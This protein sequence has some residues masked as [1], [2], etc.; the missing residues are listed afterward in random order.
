MDKQIMRTFYFLLGNTLVS[1]IVN[2]T[3]WFAITFYTYLQ[4]QS[5]LATSIISGIYLITVS[6]TGFW[7]GSIVDANKKKNVMIAS[8]LASLTFYL[9]CFA[10]YQSVDQN[11]FKDIGNPTLWVF[12][13]LTMAGVLSGNLRSIA[14]PTLVTIMIPEERRDKANGLVGTVSGVAFMIVSIFSGFL[15]AHSGMYL[16]LLLGIIL[17]VL[18]IAHLL[19]IQIPEKEIVH[20][21]ETK[22]KGRI[23]IRGTI[24][25]IKSVPGLLS[26]I[27][28]A[29]FNNFLG[30]VFMALLDA[31]G[32][33]L[34]K[35]EVWGLI[36]GFLS[37]AFIFGGM[38]VATRGLGKNP[39]KAMFTANIIIWIVSSI[40]TIQPWIVLL[41][42]GMFI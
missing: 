41:V 27:L 13:L 11:Q 15:V 21:E 7:F 14:L 33:T 17:T 24:S 34:V 37:T 42:V 12:V 40:F 19:T 10:L 20:T 28:F 23:D 3:I 18:V 5:V 30:G 9:I 22:I 1:N 39:L 4:T 8:N 16:A 26:L 38:F 36:F 25:A 32:L 6:V 31:Y 29:T 35:V 2:S